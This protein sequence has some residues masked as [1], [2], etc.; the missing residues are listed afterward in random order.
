MTYILAVDDDP[1]VLDTVGRFLQ[2]EAFEIG[3]ARSAAEALVDLERRV[4]SILIL[5]IMM[6][7]ID[8]ITLCR[9]LRRD[10]RFIALPVL[11]LTAK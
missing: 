6:P 9:Q 10:P 1:E 4:P 5:D 11:F 2:R 8:G 3:L 7:G